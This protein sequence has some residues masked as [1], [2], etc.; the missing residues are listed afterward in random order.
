MEKIPGAEAQYQE[1]ERR[2]D[3][4][5]ENTVGLLAVCRALRSEVAYEMNAL[6]D[7][8]AYLLN[9]MD[10][11]EEDDAWLDVRAAAY[12][13]RTRL[14]YVRWGL[15]GALTEL[16]H[17]ERVA[18]SRG[19]PRLH[20]LMQVERMRA[21]T[22]SDELDLAMGI[23]REMGLAP[24]NYEHDGGGDWALRQGS[25][26]V[27]IARWLVRSRR[28]RDALAFVEPAED[29]AIR[30]GQLLPLAKLRVMKAAAHWR[31]GQKG[32]ATRALLSALRLLGRQPFR[33]FILDEGQEVFHVVQAALDGDHV[34][35][36]PTPEQRRRLS[37]LSHARVLESGGAI[38]A[39]ANSG[40]QAPVDGEL[41]RKYLELLSLGLS[42][43]EIG[44]T[45]GV[46]VNTVKYHLKGIFRELRVESRLR[47]VAEARRLCIISDR[48]V[49]PEDS[50]LR[51]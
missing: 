11:I 3:R 24:D 13:V 32:D 5:G 1:L 43:K 33:R 19:M 41:S 7:A 45:M 23:M 30:G 39:H 25:I 44:R 6:G 27:A 38:L 46:S 47:A 50:G 4:L 49:W 14:A 22:L 28:C 34:G 42:N 36:P 31:L 48:A 12:R 29:F 16:G 26:A 18:A 10:S 15:P 9:A 2:L 40:D 21:L 51:H 35:V 20:R 37:E 8:D 17:C